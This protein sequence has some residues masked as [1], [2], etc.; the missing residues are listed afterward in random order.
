MP[1]IEDKT[2]GEFVNIEPS[3]CSCKRV[4]EDLLL[5]GSA[6]LWA[7]S[8]DCARVSSDSWPEKLAIIIIKYNNTKLAF[9]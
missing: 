2:N 5:V 6:I 7:R 8:K 3:L 9:S 1:I 4:W